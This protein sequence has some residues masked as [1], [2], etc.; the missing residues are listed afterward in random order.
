MNIMAKSNMKNAISRMI[1]YIFVMSCFFL[2]KKNKRSP[3]IDSFAFFYEKRIFR[4][5]FAFY[6]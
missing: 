4:G 5:S 1:S 3:K 2:L 6:L